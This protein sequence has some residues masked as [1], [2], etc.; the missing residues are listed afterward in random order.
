MAIV[1]TLLS[2][3]DGSLG[4]AV[5]SEII[6]NIQ[7]TVDSLNL[8][9]ITVTVDN[10]GSPVTVM[11]IGIF[12]NSWTGEIINNNPGGDDDY[13]IIFIRPASDPLY[14]DNQLIDIDVTAESSPSSFSFNTGSVSSIVDPT[15]TEELDLTGSGIPSGWTAISGGSGSDPTFSSGMQTITGAF[16]NSFISKTSYGL[17]FDPGFILDFEI[18]NS[19]DNMGS[20]PNKD[21]SIALVEL[22]NEAKVLIYLNPY[23]N[24]EIG[25][26]TR[27]SAPDYVDNKVS[28]PVGDVLKVK[29]RISIKLIDNEYLARLYIGFNNSTNRTPTSVVLQQTIKALGTVVANNK[30]LIGT[31]SQTDQNLF[32]SKIA[33]ANNIDPD[34][35][36]AKSSIN[37]VLPVEGVVDGGDK[38]LLSGNNIGSELISPDFSDLT[39]LSDVSQG[40]GSAIF[41]NNNI[42]NLNIDSSTASVDD[43]AVCRFS[44][45]LKSDLPGGSYTQFGIEVD[46]NLILTLPGF[47]VI[48]F[49]LEL[50]N[51]VNTFVLEM[52]ANVS[53]GSVIYEVSIRDENRNIVE[54]IDGATFF[55]QELGSVTSNIHTIGFIINGGI[56]TLFINGQEKIKYGLTTTPISLLLYNKTSQVQTVNTKISNFNVYPLIL[57]GDKPAINFINMNNNLISVFAP[58]NQNIGDVQISLRNQYFGIDLETFTYTQKLQESQIGG[59]NDVSV[60]VVDSIIKQPL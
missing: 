44:L 32:F 38:I 23:I 41:V 19:S 58:K 36:F 11:Q 6:I 55:S 12:V 40:T 30:I 10:S 2:P 1:T 35:Y 31:I 33:I 29:V 37:Y 46:S 50:K 4:N 20:G 42:L 13:T 39:W 56:I 21:I 60:Y 14:P 43:R 8:N 25:M 49:G 27:T 22:Q 7:D 45:P 57:F 28:V 9:T 48:L 16:G 24:P 54:N 52:I 3:I 26:F 18:T 51:G 59:N 17:D 15:Y 5:D 53:N 34:L 47:E